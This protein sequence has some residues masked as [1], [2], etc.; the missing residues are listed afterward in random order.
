[1]AAAVALA[2]PAIAQDEAA[3]V[4]VQQASYHLPVFSNDYVMLLNVYIP[5][6]RSSNYHTHSLD[7]VSVLIEDADQTGQVPGEP[8]T[9]S[10]RGQRGNVGFA[11]NSKTPMTHRGSN[12]GTTPFHNVVIAL[13]KPQPS[14]FTAGSRADLPGYTQVLDNERVRAWRL[15]LEP[16][17]SAGAVTQKA[18]GMRVVVDGG[19][20]VEMVPGERDRAKAMKAGEFFWQD[21]GVTRAIRNSGTSRVQFVEV[22]LK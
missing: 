22:E 21:P 7:Q 18:P 9:A 15:V 4:P 13:L 20:I 12:V 6:G 10:R 17:Q 8:P 14:G 11:F 16:G 5:P 3:P 19:E 1:M 2:G